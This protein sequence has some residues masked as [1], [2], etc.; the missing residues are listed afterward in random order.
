[1][2]RKNWL[3]KFG[4]HQTW[5][6]N[7]N[8]DKKTIKKLKNK[9]LS[10]MQL[11]III[12]KFVKKE[13]LKNKTKILTK[14]IAGTKSKNTIISWVNIYNKERNNWPV[15]GKI[16]YSRGINTKKIIKN[17]K[18][19]PTKRKWRHKKWLSDKALTLRFWKLIKN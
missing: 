6:I 11:F 15:M 19:F 16:L 18:L 12:W 4:L 2:R 10:S 13:K 8:K 7:V 14:Q 17:R 1:M 3:L 9:R 5:Q